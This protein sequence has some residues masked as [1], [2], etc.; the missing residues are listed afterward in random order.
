M[1]ITHIRNATQ[2]I[3]Y[4]GKRL[5]IDPM[6]SPK[7]AYPGFPGTAHADIR[8]PT[9]ELPVDVNT[10]LDADAVIV[11]HT[12]DD[13]WDR[14]AAELIAKDKPIYVQNDR[15]AALLRSQGFSNLTVMTDATTFGDIQITKT[16]GG[17]HGTDRAYAVPELAERLGEAC[18]VVLR[19][20]EEKTLY[21]AGDTIWREE[22]AAD[23]QKHQPDVVVLNAG[24]AHVIGFGPII[25]GQEDVLNVHFLLPQA[26]IVASHMEAINHCLLTR[27]ALREYV[28]ANQVSDAVSIPQDGETIIF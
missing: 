18:G 10:L 17:Q 7:G 22:V 16:D 25:M 2:L 4:A 27:S 13:H 23:L 28:E 3:T 26:K 6:L 19:H 15:D 9:V 11:T 20:P 8:N 14:T 21:L 1:N 12:H 24:Y 5:L